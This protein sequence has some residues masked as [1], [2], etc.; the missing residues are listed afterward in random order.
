MD[1]KVRFH[2]TNCG[3]RL[4]LRASDFPLMCHC[5]AIV[6]QPATDVEEW[7]HR[8]RTAA[9]E[10]KKSAPWVELSAEAVEA[11]LAICRDCPDG[12]FHTTDGYC[13]ICPSCQSRRKETFQRHVRLA[14]SR[15]PAKHWPPLSAAASTPVPQKIT[16]ADRIA[17]LQTP[18]EPYWRQRFASEDM[19]PSPFH[20]NPS[21]C[22]HRG[23]LYMAYRLHWQQSRIVL[24]EL[25][26][27]WPGGAWPK[28]RIA[29][30]RELDIPSSEH[31]AEA[32]EDP[33]LFVFRGQL[34]V[35]YTGTYH[36]PRL[37]HHAAVCYARLTD[38]GQVEADFSPRFEGQQPREKNWSFF[39]HDGE[40]HAVY[41]IGPRR[42]ILRID[43]RC[44][45]L[46]HDY[47]AAWPFDGGEQRGGA[48]PVLWKGEWYSFFHGVAG[49]G[50][51][52]VYTAGLYTFEDRPPFR[53]AR[54]V[55]QPLLV[56]RPADKPLES[57]PH[58]VY[59]SGAICRH[60]QWVLSIGNYDHWCEL[61]SLDW[62]YVELAL[63]PAPGGPYDG[64][65]HDLASDPLS[66]WVWR[67]VN[68]GNEYR[69]PADMTGWRVVDV[70]A[71]VGSFTRAALDRGAAHVLALEPHDGRR[72]CLSANTAGRPVTIAAAFVVGSQQGPQQLPGDEGFGDRVQSLD[73]LLPAELID[74]I[75]LDCEGS[76][77]SIVQG[78]DLSRVVRLVG[79]AHRISWRGRQWTMAD[80]TRLLEGQ[81]FTVSAE[82]T[83]EDTWLFWAER[84]TAAGP[85]APAWR[86]R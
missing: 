5:G 70:G 17:G 46:I 7:I 41:W 66:H 35:A 6:P 13:K 61:V 27:T 23:R 8:K 59:P 86:S 78:S 54:F 36:G 31:N 49:E 19:L 65:A 24:C 82:S 38:D 10:R 80:L 72:A 83:G 4:M 28:Y 40:L 64:I 74:L 39:E 22:E 58:V 76:E 73:S 33:R 44:A 60:N 18:V 84:I 67:L 26:E 52:R 69:L 45:E 55:Q 53:P 85:L 62:N 50:P 79:E 21:I 20:L 63:R 3:T 9:V 68:V 56:P 30:Q 81:G 37:V 42:R 47:E 2:C 12:H 15:C 48:P 43:G 77:Y 25:Q 51:E 1:T 29:W 75:K 32:Q 34:H 16:A 11:R 71:H 14:G 57:V